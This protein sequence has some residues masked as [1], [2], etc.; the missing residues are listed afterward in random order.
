MSEYVKERGEHLLKWWTFTSERFEPVS[1]FFMIALFVSAHYLVADASKFIILEPINILWIT[2]GTAAFFLKL[3]FYDEIKDYETDVI[4]NPTRPLPRGLLKRI[5]MKKG[6]E[7]CIILEIIFFTSCGM[8]G[9][10]AILIAIGYSLLMYKEF[11]IGDIIGPHL[12]TYATSH[13]VVTIF[14]SLSI[15]SA[16]SRYYP[17][18]H[19]ADFYYFAVLSWLLFNIF[20][21]GR[22]IYQ[23]CEERE[24]VDTYSKI[25][26]RFGAVILILVHAVGVAILTLHI[27]TIDFFFMQTYQ[28]FTIG[29]LLL[30]SAVYLVGKKPI[31]GLMYRKFSEVY[32]VLIYIGIITN[33]VLRKYYWE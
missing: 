8:P 10:V 6:I 5:D 30:V 28:A 7:Q 15:F 33:Y 26:G 4:L 9:F 13:T 18:D 22:K 31:S 2:L 11:F 21:L 12:T 25:W 32:I 17:W 19:E 27:S 1:H 3:R 16:L 14:L 20:E 24:D 29:I 23:P